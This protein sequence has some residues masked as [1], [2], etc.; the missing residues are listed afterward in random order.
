MMPSEHGRHFAD[1]LL[2]NGETSLRG[3]ENGFRFWE[4]CLRYAD[5]ILHD[6]EHCLDRP[7]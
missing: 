3:V 1:N 7:D 4:T 6:E 5:Y 2:R